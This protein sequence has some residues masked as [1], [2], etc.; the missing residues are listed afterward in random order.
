[1]S[2]YYAG[3]YDGLPR[4]DLTWNDKSDWSGPALILVGPKSELDKKFEWL[5]RQPQS[6]Q[7]QRHMRRLW[8]QLYPGRGC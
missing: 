1:M 4:A 7:R 8:S 6:R 2:D 3:Y 5:R